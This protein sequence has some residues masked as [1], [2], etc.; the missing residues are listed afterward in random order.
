MTC[1]LHAQ[2]G[3]SRKSGGQVRDDHRQ[4]YDPG[5]GGWATTARD[6]APQQKVWTCMWGGQLKRS[7][8]A[9]SC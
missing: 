6:G 5:R 4:D 2:Y 8:C 1:H 9:P 7:T 3:R